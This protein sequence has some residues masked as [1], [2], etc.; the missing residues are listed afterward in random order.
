[1]RVAAEFA[2]RGPRTLAIRTRAMPANS[3]AARALEETESSPA[4]RRRRL[5]RRRRNR[6]K[7]EGSASPS[8]APAQAVGRDAEWPIRTGWWGLG[9]KTDGTARRA[10]CGTVVGAASVRQTDRQTP[11]QMVVGNG[12]K[13]ESL[14]NP[15]QPPACLPACPRTPVRRPAAGPIATLIT[16]W[17]HTSAGFWKVCRDGSQTCVD[18]AGGTGQ[19]RSTC[20]RCALGGAC[21][22][23]GSTHFPSSSSFSEWESPL[24]GGGRS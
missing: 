11:R 12:P 18:G 9:T 15:G 20:V 24:L 23:L 4:P 22:A 1:M 10:F 8:P 17:T 13:V 21:L 3:S 19:G 7:R 16:R 14:L 6:A 5:R 2:A